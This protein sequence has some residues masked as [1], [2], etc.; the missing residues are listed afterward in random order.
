VGVE[1]M[2]VPLDCDREARSAFIWSQF[3]TAGTWLCV[4]IRKMDGERGIVS[5][6]SLSHHHHHHRCRF[7]FCSFIRLGFSK[8]FFRWDLK[9]V[10]TSFRH[11]C[12]RI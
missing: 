8:S 10:R 11:C 7:S 5:L 3:T 12:D 1:T 2:L 4:C 9:D 6:S